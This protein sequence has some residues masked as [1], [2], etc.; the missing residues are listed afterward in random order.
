MVALVGL[1]NQL[2]DLAA[3]NLRQYPVAL[4]D[5]QQN[6]VQH[7]VDALDH[8]AVDSIEDGRLAALREPTLFGGV[9]QTHNL[10]QHKHRVVLGQRRLGAH[11]FANFVPVST[12]SVAVA[13]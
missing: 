8:L 2:I 5:G 9:H 4:A 11:H 7:L 3:R 6:R 1:R 13:I 10:L 12:T